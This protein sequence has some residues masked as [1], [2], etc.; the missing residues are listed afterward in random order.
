MEISNRDR[1]DMG[2]SIIIGLS[3]DYASMGATSNFVK[4]ESGCTDADQLNV[5]FIGGKI[6]W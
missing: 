3:V 6:K 5:N 2:A 1:A 4:L